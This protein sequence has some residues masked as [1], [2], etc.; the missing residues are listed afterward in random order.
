LTSRS[1]RSRSSSLI[2]DLARTKSPF[3]RELR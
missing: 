3:V 2:T 1:K